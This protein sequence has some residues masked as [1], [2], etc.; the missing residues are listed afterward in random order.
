MHFYKIFVLIEIW[1]QPY[2]FQ[3]VMS[4]RTYIFCASNSKIY[5]SWLNELS[6]V[7]YGGVIHEGL[8]QKL[9]FI[10]KSWK[11]RYFTLNKYKQMKYY[12]DKTRTN[13]LGLIDLNL[14][15][16]IVNGKSYGV[17]HKYTIEIQT[18]NRNW[19]ICASE[20]QQKYKW[21]KIIKA[22]KYEKLNETQ[23]NNLM[24]ENLW[25]HHAKDMMARFLKSHTFLD[26]CFEP[27]IPFHDSDTK[28]LLD[29]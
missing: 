6:R 3:L 15:I 21:E 7:R 27:G 13:S 10:N 26:T 17:N 8:L 18:P 9:G 22:M 14:C 29:S 23:I 1:V 4:G 2:S 5:I 11:E 20:K 19:I 28:L 24:Q 16:L 12:T 25:K